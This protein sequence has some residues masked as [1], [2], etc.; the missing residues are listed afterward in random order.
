[1]NFLGFMFF[2]GVLVLSFSVMRALFLDYGDKI[3]AALVG[4]TLL[5][6]SSVV[7]VLPLTKKQA[8]P[9]MRLV[10]VLPLAA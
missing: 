4:D 7:V 8:R 9:A 5:A 10:D 3:V 6:R 2:F 1:M